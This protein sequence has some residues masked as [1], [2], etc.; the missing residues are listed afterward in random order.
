ML[1][2][3]A[4]RRAALFAALLCGAA[5]AV[6][7]ASSNA[8]A[9]TVAARTAPILTNHSYGTKL[10]ST[11]CREWHPNSMKLFH[12]ILHKTELGAGDRD[13]LMAFKHHHLLERK[14][15]VDSPAALNILVNGPCGTFYTLVNTKLGSTMTPDASPGGR[16][17][18]GHALA[19]LLSLMAL[20]RLGA[21]Y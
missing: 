3:M 12:G 20:A 17:R 5:H 1:P 16:K 7:A 15:A 21:A 8:S 18:P 10:N 11:E 2:T 4:P 9:A 6:H 14:W 13:N 19:A